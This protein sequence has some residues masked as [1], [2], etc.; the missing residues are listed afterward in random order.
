M[1]DAEEKLTLL[2]ERERE[3]VENAREAINTPGHECDCDLKGLLVIIDRLSHPTPAVTREQHEATEIARNIIAN[4]GISESMAKAALDIV[5]PQLVILARNYLLSGAT[6]AVDR[7]RVAKVFWD[8]DTGKHPA[9]LKDWELLR[10]HSDYGMF[11]KSY[12]YADALIASGL[13]GTKG[14]G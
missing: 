7:E 12:Q 4:G 11:Y 14:E 13:L 6:V 9:S 10:P 3:R 5:N 2:T 8:C 1:S